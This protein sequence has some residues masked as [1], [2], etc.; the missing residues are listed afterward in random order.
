M[1]LGAGAEWS[2]PPVALF[3]GAL[4]ESSAG[5]LQPLPELVKL[6]TS[7]RAAGRLAAGRR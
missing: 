3:V 7:E 6:L 5:T 2:S 4:E 1:K